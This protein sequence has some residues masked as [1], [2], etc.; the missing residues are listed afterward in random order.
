MEPR[1]GQRPPYSP[2]F[3]PKLSDA[4]SRSGSFRS[5]VGDSNFLAACRTYVRVLDPTLYNARQRVFIFGQSVFDGRKPPFF[6][7]NSLSPTV[8]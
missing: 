5:G 6:S 2:L 4:T 7:E 3:L 8:C 1:A